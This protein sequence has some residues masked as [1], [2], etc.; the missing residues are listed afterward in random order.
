MFAAGWP[1]VRDHRRQQRR[2][3]AGWRGSVSGSSRS[4][5]RGRP[6]AI[7]RGLHRLAAAGAGYDFSEKTPI[8]RALRASDSDKDLDD[9]SN[10]SILL[11]F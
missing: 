11:D 3:Y 10:Q 8:P 6:A 1:K 5:E 2:H 9:F 4:G 7:P